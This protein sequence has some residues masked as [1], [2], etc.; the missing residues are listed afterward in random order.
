VIGI[1]LVIGAWLLVILDY[2]RLFNKVTIIGVGL[3]G[4]SIGLELKKKRLAC[5]VIGVCRHQ[6]SIRLAKK[7]GVID[8]GYLQ[9]KRAVRDA[10][11]VILATPISKIISLAKEI[12]PFLKKGAIVTD[13]G[14]TK[15]VVVKRVEKIFS[16][17]IFF[18]GAHP[19]AGSEKRGVEE[20]KEGLFKGVVCII[21]QSKRTRPEALKKIS[22]LW[23]TLGA[24]VVV[25]EPGRHDRI[26]SKVSHLPHMAAVA[27]VLSLDKREIG[28]GA[29]G[30]RDTTRIASS[31]PVLWQDI[32]LTN[33]KELLRAVD[34]FRKNLE[35]LVLGIKHTDAKLLFSLLKEAKQRRD[36]LERETHN[37]STSLTSCRVPFSL[38]HSVR[39]RAGARRLTQDIIAIDGP[40]G[41]GKSTVAKLVAR[42]LGCLYIDTGAMYRALTLKALEERINFENETALVRV[43]HEASIELKKDKNGSL[44]VILDGRDVTGRIREPDVNA[45]ISRLSKVKDVRASMVARQRVL[46]A[47]DRAVLEGRDIGTVVFPRT[48]YKFYLDA[49]FRERV[50]RRYK[51]FTLGHKKI[52]WQEVRQD[53]LRRDRSDKSRKVAPLKKAAD[54][55]YIDTTKLTIAEVAKRIIS[56]IKW[57]NARRPPK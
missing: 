51:E 43:A 55:I 32:F 13:V 45:H 8:A 30:L 53:L 15:A 9:A 49:Q 33:R 20:A 6:K 4:G 36:L 29:G 19:L 38:K 14:S 46:G 40:A 44:R 24:R 47:Q 23:K 16:P 1:Y 2:M 50:N 34:K 37:P 25:M 10:D 18:V 21:T 22:R 28:F 54:A 26:L 12:S 17:K 56:Y 42:R 31:D 57:R 41:S 3:V 27:L 35:K 11:L 7:R 52:S 39:G 48:R 5:R